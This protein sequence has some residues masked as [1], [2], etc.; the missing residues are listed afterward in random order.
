MQKGVTTKKIERQPHHSTRMPPT[1]GPSAGARTTPKP[2]MPIALP[3]SPLP[4]ACRMT[5]AGIGCSTPA[6]RPSAT[7][8]ASTRSNHGLRPPPMPPTI[9]N[10]TAPM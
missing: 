8:I 6:A 2:K 1:L 5:I 9:S 10:A 4:N 3:R 7:R